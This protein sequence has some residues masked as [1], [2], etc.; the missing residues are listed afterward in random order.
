MKRRLL[1]P[2]ELRLALERLPGWTLQGGKLHRELR[3]GDF[4]GAFGFMSS[5]ALVSE[6]MNHHPEWHNVYDRVTIE[7]STHDV[8]GITALDLAWAERAEAL[9]QKPA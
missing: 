3:F 8:G 2:E 9:L 4:A 6:A 7:L 5:M 1:E